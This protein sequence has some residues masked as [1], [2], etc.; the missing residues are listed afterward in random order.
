[1]QNLQVQIGRRV[2]QARKN[3]G[4]SQDE[5]AKILGLTQGAISKIERGAIYPSVVTAM[6]LAEALSIPLVDLLGNENG[7][8]QRPA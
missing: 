8:S 5:L 6:H 1:M 3:A 2:R 4:Y 7:Q